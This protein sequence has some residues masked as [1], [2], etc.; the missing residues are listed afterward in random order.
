[1]SVV[2]GHVAQ[3][4]EKCVLAIVCR[5]GHKFIRDARYL[6]TIAHYT[7]CLMDTTNLFLA[8]ATINSR[9]QLRP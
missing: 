3:K 1:M 6:Q 4:C 7:H 8:D 9:I 2:Y 5:Y